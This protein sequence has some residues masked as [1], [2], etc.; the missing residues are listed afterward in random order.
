[1]FAP[2]RPLLQLKNA[3]GVKGVCVPCK[4]RLAK[5]PKG[6][7]KD[8]LYSLTA[9]ERERLDGTCVGVLL[10]SPEHP[11]PENLQHHRLFE[12]VDANAELL[13]LYKLNA[14]SLLLREPR[15]MSASLWEFQEFMLASGRR[16][17]LQ[18]VVCNSPRTSRLYA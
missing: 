9:E 8:I 13:S 10:T 18:Q 7:G 3:R 14:K 15:I 4:L 1:M 16:L 12:L 6:L 11:D 17:R 2:N 5:G